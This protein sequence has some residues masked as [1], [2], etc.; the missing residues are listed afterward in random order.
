MSFN[1]L[2]QKPGSVGLTWAWN[3]ELKISE[4]IEV[5]FVKEL[6]GPDKT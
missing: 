3:R 2:P 1:S 6:I 5:R 4:L